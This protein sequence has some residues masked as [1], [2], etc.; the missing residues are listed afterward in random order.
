[1]NDPIFRDTPAYA[2]KELP[3][4][5]AELADLNARI[6]QARAAELDDAIEQCK[7]IIELYGLSAYDLGLV[8]TQ[9]VATPKRFAKTFRPNAPHSA[10]P[11]K[12]R[13]PATGATWSG[14]GKPPRWIDG[15]DR[16]DYL[17]RSA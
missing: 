5:K 8:R 13:D 12:Y 7:A 14:R 6:E 3:R 11:P 9:L 4:L 16:D 1:M 2:T 15:H 10:I 17:I